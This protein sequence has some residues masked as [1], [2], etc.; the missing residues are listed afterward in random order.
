MIHHAYLHLVIVSVMYV[1]IYILKCEIM[2][3]AVD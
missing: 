2:A 3:E 1:L